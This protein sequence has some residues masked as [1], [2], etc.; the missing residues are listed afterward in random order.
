MLENMTATLSRIDEIKSR[1]Q[2]NPVRCVVSVAPHAAV[3]TASAPADAI[4]PFFP[5]Y[6]AQ[7]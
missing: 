4:K 2:Q 7:F 5:D 1:F 6:L 3:Q